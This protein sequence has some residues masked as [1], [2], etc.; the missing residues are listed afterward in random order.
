MLPFVIP[1]LFHVHCI[2]VVSIQGNQD[3]RAIF[4]MCFIGGTENS[5]DMPERWRAITSDFQQTHSRQ[6]SV[7][8]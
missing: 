2:C 6:W 1:Q 5:Y 4:Q 8:L 3:Y 7:M